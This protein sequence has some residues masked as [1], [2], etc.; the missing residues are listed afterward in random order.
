MT[1][2]FRL[3][4]AIK[5]SFETFKNLYGKISSR[6]GKKSRNYSGGEKWDEA[7]SADGKDE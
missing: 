2:E 1:Q 3:K 7:E 5:V 4:E 6:L